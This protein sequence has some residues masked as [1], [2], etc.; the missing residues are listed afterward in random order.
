MPT[1]NAQEIIQED[2]GW[3]HCCEN[4]VEVR[5]NDDTMELECLSCGGNFV[6]LAGQGI[7]NFTS[8][9]HTYG[10]GAEV[11]GEEGYDDEVATENEG[12]Y[13]FR[14]AGHNDSPNG[15]SSLDDNQNNGDNGGE[16][17]SSTQTNHTPT[18]EIVQR[19]M[20]R[21]LRSQGL[22]TVAS[23][24]SA[25]SVAVILRQGVS[26]SASLPSAAALAPTLASLNSNG[27]RDGINPIEIINSFL[28][29]PTQTA[30]NNNEGPSGVG[31]GAD[32]YSAILSRGLLSLSALSNNLMEGI[33]DTGLVGDMGSNRSFENLLH[34]LMMNESSHASHPVTPEV[35]KKLTRVHINKDTDLMK[36][37][38]SADVSCGITLDPL[39]EGEVAVVLKCKHVY[40]EESILEWFRQH[41]TCPVCRKN[42]E[43][44]EDGKNTP[45]SCGVTRDDHVT[46][47]ETEYSEEAILAQ[48]VL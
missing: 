37:C 11:Q 38:G 33:Q 5:K 36:E 48:S 43:W 34:H 29:S 3:C 32:A 22:Q 14:V 8:V 30:S 24:G 16:V 45:D 35:I 25:R 10:A 23:N 31:G 27:G 28:T 12:N 2:S 17:E 1:V 9:A 20:N 7:E 41:N 18:A 4:T 46:E 21:A 47:E 13:S 15:L 19:I 42:V 6:E 44:E 39:E 40:K 26:S